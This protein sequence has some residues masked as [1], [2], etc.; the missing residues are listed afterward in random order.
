MQIRRLECNVV[1]KSRYQQTIFEPFTRERNTTTSKIP[2]TGLGMP[3]VKRLVDMMSGT[4]TIKSRPGRGSLFTV[5]LPLEIHAF[6]ESESDE[7]SNERDEALR[8]RGRHVLIAEDNDLN[9]E[10]ALYIL[11]EIGV[12][13]DRVSDGRQC[14]N[15]LTSAP[16]GTYDAI[17][18]DIQMPGMDGYEATR[19]IRALGDREKARIPILAMTANAF[20]EDKSNAVTAGMNGHVPK[21]V[22]PAVL[23]SALAAVI[24]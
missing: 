1:G 20:Q 17:L 14:V 11:E 12:S 9:A 18:M 16:A 24:G 5:C 6:P 7:K 15:Q 22:D 10:I 4:I 19:A 21:P 13:A 23:T 3:I 2:G 8:I